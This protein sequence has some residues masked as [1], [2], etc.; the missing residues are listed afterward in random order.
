MGLSDLLGYIGRASSKDIF[1]VLTDLNERLSAWATQ[2][3]IG[4]WVFFLVGLLA[5]F[6]VGFFGYKLIKLILALGFGYIGYFVGVALTDVLT[7]RFEWLPEWSCYIFG[8]LVAILFLCMAFAK[9][10]YALFS[11]FAFAGYCVTMFYFDNQVL[12]VGGAIVLAVLSVTLIRTVFILATSFGCG[13]LSVSFLAQLLPKVELL[14]MGEGKWFALCLA[15]GLTAV[16]AVV[17]FVI[18]RRCT[19]TVEC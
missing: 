1:Q 6:A 4:A 17:Q 3:D 15:L 8:A 7:D 12:A 18:N 10:S 2:L 16:F 13:M 5:T 19:E 11:V 14:Q 9:F